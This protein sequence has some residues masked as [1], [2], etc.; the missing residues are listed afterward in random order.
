MGPCCSSQLLVEPQPQKIIVS[1]TKSS[2]T[3]RGWIS[4]KLCNYLGINILRKLVGP[5]FR[6]KILFL[7]KKIK[8]A[9]FGTLNFGNSKLR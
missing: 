7:I 1:G 6:K 9:F 3:S 2:D 4:L 5:D 8:R